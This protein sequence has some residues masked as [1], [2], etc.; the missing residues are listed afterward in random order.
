MQ[1]LKQ[2]SDIKKQTDVNNF[3]LREACRAVLFD[4]YQKVPL[5]Y[6]S[7]YDYYK[8]PGGG[9]DEGEGKDQALKRECLEEVGSEI[10]VIGEI[11]YVI[12]EREGHQL[13]QISYSYFGKILSKGKVDF[14][15]KEINDGFELAWLD[16]DEAINKIKNSNPKCYEGKFIQERDLVI[17]T[18]VKD[19]IS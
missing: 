2:I 12:E 5:L 9:I 1:L 19:I 4:E 7:L 17:I 11:G 16:L 6:V 15:Q 13:K 10:E 18:K 14:T 3:K 8:L